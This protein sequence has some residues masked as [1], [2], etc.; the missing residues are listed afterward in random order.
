MGCRADTLEGAAAQRRKRRTRPLRS[1][2]IR[3]SFPTTVGLSAVC[4][5][6]TKFYRQILP[7]ADEEVV[8]PP[9]RNRP[10]IIEPEDLYVLRVAGEVDVE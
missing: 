2:L 3:S 9:C 1:A 10:R 7:V 5:F 4:C 8:N 6:E